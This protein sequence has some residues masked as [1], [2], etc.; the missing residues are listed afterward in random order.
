M[1]Y[2]CREP[3]LRPET[4]HLEA[5]P[6]HATAF[7]SLTTY[8]TSLP[9]PVDSGGDQVKVTD[10]VVGRAATLRGLLAGIISLPATIGGEAT[11]APAALRAVTVKL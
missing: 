8:C 9:P 7:P 5:L 4:S 11:L 10:M 2:V 6:V 1:E 3:G